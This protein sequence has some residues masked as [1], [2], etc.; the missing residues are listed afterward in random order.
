MEL[1]IVIG[2]ALGGAPCN[3]GAKRSGIGD[4]CLGAT[5]GRP[6]DD[7]CLGEAC[8]LEGEQGS[9]IEVQW[10]ARGRRS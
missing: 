2:K 1:E 6:R 5:F 10:S 9:L 8:V 4:G 7:H 3:S